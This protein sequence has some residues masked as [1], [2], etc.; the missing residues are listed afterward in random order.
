[1]QTPNSTYTAEQIFAE[2]TR[3][4]AHQAI[5]SYSGGHDE[6]G[7]DEIAL[8]ANGVEFASLASPWPCSTAAEAELEA[9]IDALA[10]PIYARFG[11]FDGATEVDGRLIWDVAERTCVAQ[12]SRT[13]WV[14]DNWNAE[15]S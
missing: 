4:G 1:M 13:D 10:A 9:F 6:G 2:L 11:G 12:G 15:V 14:D 7:H 5:V 8:L 3:R